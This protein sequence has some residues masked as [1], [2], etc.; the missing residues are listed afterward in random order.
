M[1]TETALRRL[2]WTIT[3]SVGSGGQ[4]LILQAEAT[5]SGSRFRLI[6]NCLSALEPL[7]LYRRLTKRITRPEPLAGIIPL[8]LS[9]YNL[10]YLTLT[11]IRTS[12]RVN[13]QYAEEALGTESGR[14]QLHTL[15]PAVQ[16]L[17]S[18]FLDEYLAALAAVEVDNNLFFINLLITDNPLSMLHPQE[19]KEA[20]AS[21]NPVAMAW[22]TGF[23]PLHLPPSRLQ[24]V[25][26]ENQEADRVAALPAGT[27]S[28]QN[29]FRYLLRQLPDI[30]WL[31][32]TQAL[33]ESLR[34]ILS[35]ASRWPLRDFNPKEPEQA[36]RLISK[37]K[38]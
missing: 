11:F 20:L 30:Y 4:E 18:R 29:R 36:N 37:K 19:V 1:Q 15:L 31:I 7:L 16:R 27:A 33:E 9:S 3:E 24:T 21:D 35:Y 8:N 38:T 5:R 34:F 2:G 28:S 26:T 23:V 6:I 25:Q 17:R 13:F 32:S 12:E 22:E 10:P 14:D